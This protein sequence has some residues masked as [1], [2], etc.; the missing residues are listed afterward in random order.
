MDMYCNCFF[1]IL[2]S[3]TRYPCISSRAEYSEAKSY[4]GS[5]ACARFLFGDRQL[6]T[7]GGTDASLMIW[8]LVEE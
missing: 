2:P 1:Y 6:V 3:P 5:V 4:S 8:D 7:V